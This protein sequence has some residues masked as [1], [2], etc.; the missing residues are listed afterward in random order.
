[1]SSIVKLLDFVIHSMFIKPRRVIS[2]DESAFQT[3]YKFIGIFYYFVSYKL[4]NP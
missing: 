3:R 2:D 4:T 1:M